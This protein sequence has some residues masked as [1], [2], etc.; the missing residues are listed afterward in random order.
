MDTVTAAHTIRIGYAF[1][2]LLSFVVVVA[3]CFLRVHVVVGFMV[4]WCWCGYLIR[5]TTA[6]TTTTTTVSTARSFLFL[7]DSLF[8]IRIPFDF[9]SD[10]FFFGA[11]VSV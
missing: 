9:L 5:P 8:T 6:T 3:I 10:L 2:S 11:L 7:F 1:L 4:I